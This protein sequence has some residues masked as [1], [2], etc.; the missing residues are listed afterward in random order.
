MRLVYM[1]CYIARDICFGKSCDYIIFDAQRSNNSK[2]VDTKRTPNQDK[3]RVTYYTNNGDR[4][5]LSV[6]L[7]ECFLD[8]FFFSDFLRFTLLC[9]FRLILSTRLIRSSTLAY[10]SSRV[11]LLETIAI[12]IGSSRA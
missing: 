4:N 6:L 9:S 2:M 10:F 3:A 1:S 7:L 11:L 5:K 8:F 12:I